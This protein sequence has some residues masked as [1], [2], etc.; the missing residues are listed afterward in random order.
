M[1]ALPGLLTAGQ[2]YG[3]RVTGQVEGRQTGFHDFE[4]KSLNLGLA[5]DA[6]LR[7]DQEQVFTTAEYGSEVFP[8]VNR[9]AHHLQA[10]VC[11]DLELEVKF[12]AV[13]DA[14]FWLVWREPEMADAFEGTAFHGI[15]Q[16]QLYSVS[17]GNALPKVKLLGVVHGERLVAGSPLQVG[18][19][20]TDADG[21]VVRVEYLRDGVLQGEALAAPW[22][23][24]YGVLPAGT[25][26]LEARAIDDDGAVR[27]S[28][29][30]TVTVQ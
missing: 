19:E 30:V 28:R 22:T 25:W 1:V 12:T 6:T 18:A 17:G 24:D 26:N 16:S 2:P 21:S 8:A 4:L 5:M 29:R 11:E 13:A 23:F 3:L 7:L 10:G 14:G 20:A 27:T 9:G 15:P